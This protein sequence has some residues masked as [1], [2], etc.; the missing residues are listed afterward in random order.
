MKLCR[1]NKKLEREL[2]S[3]LK[4]GLSR[5]NDWFISI[6]DFLQ[7]K[8]NSYSTG[9]KKLLLLLFVL[10]FVAESGVVIIQSSTRKNKTMLE[11][12]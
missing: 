8:T 9:K 6:A 12:K 5:F 2:P 10:V 4:A 11:V 7:R 3:F 1:K